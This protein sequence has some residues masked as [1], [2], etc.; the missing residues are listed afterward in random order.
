MPMRLPARRPVEIP[1]GWSHQL[2][3]SQEGE[4]AHTATL[5]LGR[6]V[7]PGLIERLLAGCYAL[8]KHHYFWRSGA[9]IRLEL[10]EHGG[11][12]REGRLLLDV[13]AIDGPETEE[14]EG[15]CKE[16]ALRFEALGPAAC[17]EALASVLAKAQG[18]L[19]ELL[20]DFPGM[21]GAAAPPRS[22]AGAAEW[23]WGRG[24]PTAEAA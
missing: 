24:V 8:G 7:P 12:K 16:Y 10:G 19:D 21:L 6:F 22:R 14:S 2:F 9:L 17:D 18:L 3:A 1:S 23:W 11:A 13:D 15:A 5:G 20:R 4:A